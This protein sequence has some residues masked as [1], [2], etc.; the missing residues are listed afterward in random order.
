MYSLLKSWAQDGPYRKIQMPV[1]STTASK[2]TT[3][4]SVT[5]TPDNGDNGSSS[6]TGKRPADAMLMTLTTTTMD[7]TR[8][9]RTRNV[10]I[11]TEKSNM[12][13]TAPPNLSQQLVGKTKRVKRRKQGVHKARMAIALVSLERR[14]I[15]L[16]T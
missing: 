2:S 6:T 13:D 8:P 9:P 7:T 15:H 14:G 5:V 4:V 11:D 1:M 16:T 10:S 12:N 3:A